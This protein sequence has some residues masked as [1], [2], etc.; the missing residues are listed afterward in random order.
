MH[1]LFVINISVHPNKPLQVGIPLQRPSSRPLL[2]NTRRNPKPLLTTV[3]ARKLETPYPQSLRAKEE[4]I[5]ALFGLNPVSNF[6]GFA[7][8]QLKAKP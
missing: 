2:C 4:G 8:W 3:E 1:I 5:P 7:V 6:M